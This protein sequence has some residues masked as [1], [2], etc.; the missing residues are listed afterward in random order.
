MRTTDAEFELA[1]MRNDKA[2]KW[3]RKNDPRLN[4]SR[5]GKQRKPK[6]S[7]SE[8]PKKSALRPAFFGRRSKEAV[9]AEALKA[10]SEFQQGG[11]VIQRLKPASRIA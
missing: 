8:K 10:V 7:C 1:Q 5:R 3:L 6:S 9:R 2:A 11:G 4:R